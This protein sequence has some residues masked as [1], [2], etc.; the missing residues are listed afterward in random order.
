MLCEMLPADLPASTCSYGLEKK[1]RKKGKKKLKKER[2]EKEVNLQM[3]RTYLETDSCNLGQI[4]D[5]LGHMS[6]Q[7]SGN[8]D[9]RNIEI[10]KQVKQ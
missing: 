7:N 8:L 6:R 3:K 9:H 2:R 4:Q 10:N 5:I 1:K